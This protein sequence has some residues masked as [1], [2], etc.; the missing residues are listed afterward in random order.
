METMHEFEDQRRLVSE[1]LARLGDAETKLM[2]GEMLRKKLHNT[3]LVIPR[4]IN[5]V[6][7]A[8]LLFFYSLSSFCNAGIERE[9]SCI[10]SSAT[11]VT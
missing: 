11:F 2:E 6:L 3:I 9:H 10:L 8:V 5:I 4:C 1:L 7:A